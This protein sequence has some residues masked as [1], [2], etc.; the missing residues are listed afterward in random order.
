[1]RSTTEF[2]RLPNIMLH[3]NIIQQLVEIQS[4]RRPVIVDVR[5]QFDKLLSNPGRSFRPNV[6]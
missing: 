2:G 5:H 6:S 4:E 3:R 1:M